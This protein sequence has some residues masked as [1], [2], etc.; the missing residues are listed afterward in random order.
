M[1]VGIGLWCTPAFAE[2]SEDAGA[3]G[4]PID[5]IVVTASKADT[6]DIGGSVQRLDTADLERFS[7]NDVNRILRQVPGVYLQEEDG[8]G[9]RPNIGIRG[10]GTDRSARVAVMEDGV[11][12]APAP[13]AAPAAYYFPRVARMSGVE[14]AKGPAA[15]KY[16][17]MTV[18]G[19]LNLFST[20]I[21]D[22]D[23]G[24][25]GTDLGRVALDDRLLLVR[26]AVALH[27]AQVDTRGQGRPRGPQ[28]ASQLAADQGSAGSKSG[29]EG[30]KGLAE[31]T[32]GH[33]GHPRVGQQEGH[34][35]TVTVAVGPV[36]P[37]EVPMIGPQD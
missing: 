5:A 11:L 12:I 24:T 37:S 30:D 21:P 27:H 3:A 32:D 31:V 25:H 16:G 36:P 17:P 1:A 34:G 14:V 20:P 9:L 2:V 28:P 35:I 26:R 29:I 13:Y 4:S 8:F 6:I 18:G 10:S 22:V 33:G 23:A 7:Y 15:I 19:A